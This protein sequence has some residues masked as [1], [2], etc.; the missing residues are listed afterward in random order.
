MMPPP[1]RRVVTPPP[2][3][4]P[5]ESTDPLLPPEKKQASTVCTPCR[6]TLRSPTK[7]ARPQTIRRFSN[8]LADAKDSVPHLQQ[9]TV[10]IA[11][12]LDRGATESIE[13]DCVD[14]SNM[15]STKG[16]VVP[17]VSPTCVADIC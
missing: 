9:P 12:G 6:P 16:E 14:S 15:R 2:Q 4:Q 3:K 13:C 1:L 17:A 8:V 10:A 11:T 5:T 7:A